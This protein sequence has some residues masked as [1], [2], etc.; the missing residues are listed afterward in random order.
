MYMGRAKIP[1]INAMLRN[2]I[3]GI[4][5]LGVAVVR[6]DITPNSALARREQQH[7]RLENQAVIGI[8]E[9]TFGPTFVQR[10]GSGSKSGISLGLRVFENDALVTDHSRLHVRYKEG[11]YVELGEGSYFLVERVRFKPANP[12]PVNKAADQFDESVFRFSHGI[13]RV[14]APDVHLLEHFTIKTANGLIRV[15]GPSDFFLIQLEGDRDIAIRVVRGKVEVTNVVTNEQVT[16]PE[17]SGVSLKVT[18]LISETERLSEEQLN[19]LKS[20]TRI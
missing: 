11:T 7:R 5:G 1:T 2:L 10:G 14:T 18:G 3:F 20:R 17:G 16:V 9:R 13:I 12:L 19:F 8:V 4:L 6:G 15:T